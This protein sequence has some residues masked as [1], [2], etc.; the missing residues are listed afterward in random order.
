MHALPP[1]EALA[2]AV[3][4]VDWSVVRESAE[5]ELADRWTD[6]A[7]ASGAQVMC[8]VVE[9]NVSEALLQVAHA[10]QSSLIVVGGHGMGRGRRHMIGAAAHRILHDSD[11][12]VVVVRDGHAPV[13]PD[14]PVVV[15]VGHGRA[16]TAALEWA[17]GFA[18]AHHLPVDLVRVIEH[19]P[20]LMP[21]FGVEAALAKAAELFDPELLRTWNA[22]DLERVVEQLRADDSDE[23]PK[24][25]LRS[26]VEAGPIGKVLE[27]ESRDAGLLVIGKR[28]D[29][30]L[31]GYFTTSTLHHVLTHGAVPIAVIPQ[32]PAD[33]P[34]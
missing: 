13:Q 30:P 29:G 19:Q 15:G 24:V 21:S 7:R 5:R 8:H 3:L 33:E 23:G 32:E 27:E 17:V 4:Q 31:T 34:L 25:E 22:E 11:L 28:Y 6:A 10:V 14:A 16:T 26:H 18:A 9:A 1:S 12:P 20:L 2:V